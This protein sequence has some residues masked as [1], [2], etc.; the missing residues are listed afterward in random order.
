MVG[1]HDFQ[2]ISVN[3][4]VSGEI[5][6]IGNFIS[7]S[8]AAGLLIIVYSISDKFSAWY[9]F[10]SHSESVVTTI[11]GLP[12]GEYSISVF[13][14]EASGLPFSRSAMRPRKVSI[15]EGKHGMHEIP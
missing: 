4:S 9:I 14:I 6:V 11:R 7:N 8:T 15:L 12:S 10:Q 2:N 5:K 13:I 1:T 3:S